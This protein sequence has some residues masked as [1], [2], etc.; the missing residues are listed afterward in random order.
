MYPVT[1][2]NEE[3]VTIVLNPTTAAGNPATVDGAPVWSIESGDATLEVA[4]DGLSCVIISGAADVVNTISVTAD[5]DMGEGVS[6]ISETIVY[7][8]TAA[9]AAGLGVSSS[10]S[11]K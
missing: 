2:T 6:S 5:A 11:P 10:V 8:V 7:T 3:K 9:Q 4:A 1:S